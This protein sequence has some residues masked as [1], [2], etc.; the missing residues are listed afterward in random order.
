MGAIRL[1]L[2]DVFAVPLSNGGLG[3]T[4]IIAR[5]WLGCVFEIFRERF[6]PGALS[7]HL[8]SLPA[9]TTLCVVYIN[10]SSVRSGWRRIGKLPEQ[11]DPAVRPFTSYGHPALGWTI[12][13]PRGE[14]GVRRIRLAGDAI[15]HEQLQARGFVDATFWLT[16]NIQ[17]AIESGSPPSSSILGSIYKS[18]APTATAPASNPPPKKTAPAGKRRG[19]SQRG[20]PM[21]HPCVFTLARVPCPIP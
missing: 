9:L 5:T 11:T 18:P 10:E 12:E 21:K 16:R 20:S 13:Q 8:K 7:T 6:A 1:N 14:T 19:R 2:G 3:L 15:T 17:R 4:M